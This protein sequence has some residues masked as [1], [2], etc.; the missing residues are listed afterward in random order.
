MKDISLA[1]ALDIQTGGW[2]RLGILR[3]QISH[4]HLRHRI[5]IK[6]GKTV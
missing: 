6:T 4:H 1:Q 5:K 2:N 3:G